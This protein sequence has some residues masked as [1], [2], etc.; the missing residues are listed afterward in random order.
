MKRFGVPAT[1]RA[2]LAM[3]SQEWEIDALIRGLHRVRELLA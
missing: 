1:V 2:T 3:Y